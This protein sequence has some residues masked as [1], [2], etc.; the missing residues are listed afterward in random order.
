MAHVPDMV[1]HT[2]VVVVGMD[3]DGLVYNCRQGKVHVVGKLAVGRFVGV[4][5]WG[6][7]LMLEVWRGSVKWR[8][9]ACWICRCLW[10]VY[11]WVCMRTG[12]TMEIWLWWCGI[13]QSLGIVVCVCVEHRYVGWV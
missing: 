11:V 2:F 1:E 7:V 9:I 8:L 10:L 12:D 13:R 4:W 6:G 3:W 5:I